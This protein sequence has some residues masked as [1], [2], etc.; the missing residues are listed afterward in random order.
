MS[1]QL[2]DF[3]KWASL[4]NLREKMN[5]PLTKDFFLETII[6]EIS[7]NERLR[8]GGVEINIDEVTIHNDGTLLYNN[9]R[10]LLHIRDISSIS[11]EFRMPKYH[12]ANCQILEKMRRNAR[13]DRY[14]VAN[15]DTGEF[16]VNIIDRNIKNQTVRLD[17]CQSCLDRIHWRG[18]S[19]QSTSR[20]ERQN[21]VANFSL[22]DFFKEYPRD[23]IG[24]KPKHT[25]DTA[26]LNNYADNW[27]ELSMEVRLKR[28]L[29]C[30]SCGNSFN[31]NESRFLHVHHRNGLK[32]DNS[33]S[34]LVVLCIGCHA[35]Q[36]EHGHMKNLPDYKAF[37]SRYKR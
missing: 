9:K 28:G 32:N 1:F 24:L 3:L 12:L 36:P 30:E 13:F 21:R 16:Q 34:N 10:I 29:R 33:S 19:M 11:G 5:A 2:P 37:M 25:S 17:V 27:K 7:I 15:R 6:P 20:D 31:K 8:S 18:F 35:E 23:L 22:T 26:P 14:V 4:N